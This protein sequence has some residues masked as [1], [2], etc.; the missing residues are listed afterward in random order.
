MTSPLCVAT[1][2]WCRRVFHYR[3][4]TQMYRN[5]PPLCTIVLQIPSLMPLKMRKVQAG[6]RIA[7]HERQLR[8]SAEK[9]LDA[10]IPAHAGWRCRDHW[11]SGGIDPDAVVLVQSGPYG[12]GW[13]MFEYERSARGK[14]GATKK[15]DGYMSN[16]RRRKYPAIFAVR[17]S[18]MEEHLHAVARDKQ[19]PL[20]TTTFPRLKSC[21]V[22]GNTGCWS[23]YG[24]PV[25]LG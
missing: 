16:P 17:D 4:P 6:A 1:G 3:P 22:V 5:S 13:H 9:F 20:L 25:S 12:P 11:G 15:L 19:L 21:N 14:Y 2:G 18:T 8:S 7:V 10:G 24:K 23:Q